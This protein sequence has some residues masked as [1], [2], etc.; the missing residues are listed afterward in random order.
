VN[1]MDNDKDILRKSIY[2]RLSEKETVYG[3]CDK[4]IGDTFQPFDN[5]VFAVFSRNIA[6]NLFGSD[7]LQ[8]MNDVSMFFH[9]PWLKKEKVF[10]F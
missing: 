2:E 6:G 7:D 5:S 10:D 3:K 1:N 8:F 9:E 4:V